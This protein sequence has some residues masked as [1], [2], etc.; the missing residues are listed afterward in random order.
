MN[1][2]IFACC[3]AKPDHEYQPIAEAIGEMIAIYGN[4]LATGGSA[5]DEDSIMRYIKYGYEKTA[6]DLKEVGYKPPLSITTT[7][8]MI[9]FGNSPTDEIRV[10]DNILER[11]Q[12]LLKSSD[13]VLILNGG[14]GTLAELMD[15]YV[16]R[17]TKEHKDLKIIIFNFNGYWDKLYELVENMY[18]RGKCSKPTKFIHWVTSL[19]ELEEI[20][21]AI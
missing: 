11:Q 16:L 2:T 7:K 14:M 6:K 17:Q 8:F 18:L 4:R 10:Y 9:E 20:L 19:E 15:A 13:V 21:K 5:D 1:K 12:D 3:S